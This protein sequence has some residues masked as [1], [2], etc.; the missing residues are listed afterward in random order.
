MKIIKLFINLILSIST[1]SIFAEEPPYHGTIFL[2][3]NIINSSD[4]SSFDSLNS[5][6][7]QEKTVFDRRVN[8]WTTIHA[9]LYKVI[10]KDDLSSIAVVNP[11]FT[12]LQ[13]KSEAKKYALLIGQLPYI[14]RK[15]IK[16]I[17]IHKG[18]ELFGG[19]NQSILIHTGQ[20][21]IYEKDGI[22]EETLIH[23]AVHTS[24]DDE[25][26]KSLDWLKAQKQDG[27]FISTYAKEN[28]EREDLAES[29][30][31]WLALRFKLSKVSIE[32]QKI[33][34]KTI[35]SRLKYFDS[36]KFIISPITK[37]K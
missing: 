16:E 15:D 32:N 23:E 34:N 13:A 12:E 35:P 30:L 37:P 1:L 26:S 14:L 33:I 10:W 7:K 36:K 31:L 3:P 21:S 17:W 6:G 2:E 25:H 29:F 19:G 9:Y 5:I 28:P 27:N 8:N 18:V 11:E 20:S 4:P 24:L 22:L